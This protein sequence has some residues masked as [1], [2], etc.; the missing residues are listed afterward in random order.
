MNGSAVPQDQVHA[1]L[2]DLGRLYQQQTAIAVLSQAAIGARHIEALLPDAVS[3][4]ASVLSLTDVTFDERVVAGLVEGNGSDSGFLLADSPGRRELTAGEVSFVNAIAG[5]LRQLARQ[6]EQERVALDEERQRFV[7][8]FQISPVALGMSTLDGGR[9]LDVNERW[10]SLLGYE[11]DEVIG[12]T[13]AELQFTMDPAY[14]SA[15]ADQVRACGAL[16]DLELRLRTRS[17]DQ[18]D[19]MVSAVPFDTA[20][21]RAWISA[22]VDITDRKRVETERDLLLAREQAA[23]AEAEQAL[24]KLD[25]VYTIADGGL[26]EGDVGEQLEDLLKRLRRTLQLDFASVLSLDEAGQGMYLRAWAGPPGA[27]APSTGRVPRGVGLSARIFAE[28]RPLIADDYSKVDLSGV[29]GVPLE[30]IRRVTKS[31]MGAPFR[32]RGKIAGVVMAVNSEPRRFTA[33]ELKLLALAADRVAPAIERGRLI[34]KIRSGLERQRTLSYRLLNAQEEERRRLAVE[35]HD[36]LGQVLTAVKINLES[37]ERTSGAA[38]AAGTLAGMIS[39]VDDALQHVRDIALDLRPSVL[40]DLGLSAA[41]RWYVDRFARAG[42]IEA[43]LS[44]GKLTRFEPELETACFRVAQEAL[45]NVDRHSQAKH[46]WIDLHLLAGALELSIRDDGIGF[47][48]AAARERAIHGASVGLLGM[49]ERVSLM[50]GEYEVVRVTAGG[51]EVRARFPL[52]MG[53]QP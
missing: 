49:Q 28:G 2:E 48:V 9:I 18:L 51:T 8:I 41:L 29:E 16:R 17:G 12:K 6:R 45:T 30:E 40:D 52:A 42:R 31:V 25:A 23:R 3:L 19:V 24:E 5:V 34:A 14:R 39:S 22:I 13:N 21:G 43:H 15:L 36:E 4:V 37:L 27:P 7:R 20:T 35:L 47:D 11:R 38:T 46:V 44:I 53:P 1:V 33:E 10:L 32:I 26:A 50:D